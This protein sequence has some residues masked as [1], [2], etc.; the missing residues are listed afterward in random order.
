MIPIVSIQSFLGENE[1]IKLL[2]LVAIDTYIIN[3][4]IISGLKA[5][6]I[7]KFIDHDCE[8]QK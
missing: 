3:R 8:N 2:I 6:M 1:T 7:W 4:M 5:G